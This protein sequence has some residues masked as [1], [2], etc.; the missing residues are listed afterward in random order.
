MRR[1]SGVAV[2]ILILAVALVA[3]PASMAGV[4]RGAAA[5]RAA[6]TVVGL[7]RARPATLP[8]LRRAGLSRQPLVDPYA[9]SATIAIPRLGV[10]APVYERGLDGVGQPLIAPGYSVTHYTFSDPLGAPGNYV[11]Y[12]H[13]DIEGS[14]FRALDTLRPGDRI[15]LYSGARRFIYRVTDSTVVSPGAT[16]VMNSTA[17]ATLTMISC[18][19]YWVDTQRLIVKAVLSR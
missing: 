14:I 7:Q 13:N 18:T 19:P 17:T 10:Q 9:P 15:Y 5:S 12:G 16:Y 2:A 3:L 6:T 11:I 4:G 8:G 1:L